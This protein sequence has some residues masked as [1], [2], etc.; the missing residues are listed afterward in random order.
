MHISLVMML[1]VLIFSHNSYQTCENTL[2]T[3][4]IIEDALWL[5]VFNIP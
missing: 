3:L 2:L 4:E 5:W 1:E